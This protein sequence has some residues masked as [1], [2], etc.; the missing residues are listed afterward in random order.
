MSRIR[1]FSRSPTVTGRPTDRSRVNGLR[2]QVLLGSGRQSAMISG[3]RRLPRLPTEEPLMKRKKNLTSWKTIFIALAVT[4]FVANPLAHGQQEIILASLNDQHGAAY[5]R[6]S[7]VLA[8]GNFY[9]TAS[10]D[11]AYDFGG[12]VFELTPNGRGGWKELV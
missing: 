2:P 10:Q 9:G 4:F 1:H 12:A 8:G 5:P 3:G 7:L 6:A 11:G